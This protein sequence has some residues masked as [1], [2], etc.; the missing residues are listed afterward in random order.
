MMIPAVP[1]A[2]PATSHIPI[3]AGGTI[4]DHDTSRSGRYISSAPIKSDA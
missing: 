1:I 2:I 4:P 3:A